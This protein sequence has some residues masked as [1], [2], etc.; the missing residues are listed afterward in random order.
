ML[1][2]HSFAMLSYFTTL[3]TFTGGPSLSPCSAKSVSRMVTGGQWFCNVSHKVLQSVS[4]M[5]FC[6]VSQ[7]TVPEF[8]LSVS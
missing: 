3:T 5:D 4:Q 2:E 8:W 6:T 1:L 7:M